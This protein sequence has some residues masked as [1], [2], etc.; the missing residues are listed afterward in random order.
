M[1]PYEQIYDVDLSK[2]IT[3]KD[4]GTLVFEGDNNSIKVGSNVYNSGAPQQLSGSIEGK[5]IRQDGGTVYY[6]G[7]I[8]DNTGYITLTEA[9]F[10]YPG[11][12]EIFV[13]IVSG[14]DRITIGAFKAK[15]K[16]TDTG[17]AIDPGQPV[18]GIAELAEDVEELKIGKKNTQTA[19]SSPAASGSTLA[20]IDTI[21]QNEQGV[22]AAT[23]KSV[24]VDATP[25]A[26]STNPVQSGGVKAALDGKQDTLT[27]PLAISQGG[28]GANTIDEA[29]TNLTAPKGNVPW[30]DAPVGI[31]AYFYE[32]PDYAQFDV[33]SGYCTVIVYKHSAT[34]GTA[35]ATNWNF[36]AGYTTRGE[37]W[38]NALHNYWTGWKQI[39]WNGAIPI[40]RGGTGATTAESARAYLGCR[41]IT[42]NMGTVTGTGGTVTVTKTVTGVTSSMTVDRIEFGTPSAVQSEW[43]VTT[44]ANSVTFTATI[45]GSTTVKIKLSDN[46]DVTGT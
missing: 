22:I 43:T 4:I 21:S 40:E 20:F 37:T 33:P 46:I 36:N 14:Q 35:I 39:S 45:S 34:R 7:T 24:T 29:R 12:I 2:G 25:T 1:N 16:R 28:T 11:P 3:Q 19:V 15:A 17:K 23:K 41:S 8:S 6:V 32:I 10:A 38:V 30:K 26:N 42:A 44:A 9:A 27:L 31:T 5:V 13:R 18:P